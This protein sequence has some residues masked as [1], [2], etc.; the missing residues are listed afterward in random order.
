MF[1]PADM[2]EAFHAKLERRAPVFP[3]LLPEPAGL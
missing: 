2:A 3:E 1:Q